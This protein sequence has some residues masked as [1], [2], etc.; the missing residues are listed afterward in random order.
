M[1]SFLWCCFLLL[2]GWSYGQKRPVIDSLLA[3]L[4]QQAD[5][6]K[7]LTY[8]QLCW[9][10][11]KEDVDSALA[12]GQKGLDLA[13]QLHFQR[14]VFE[15]YQQLG[16]CFGRQAN[17]PKALDYFLKALPIAETLTDQSRLARLLQNIGVIHITQQEYA[18]SLPFFNRALTVYKQRSDQAGQIEVLFLIAD[19]YVRLRQYDWGLALYKQCIAYYRANRLRFDLAIAL[20]DY[21]WALQRR[22]NFAESI[23]P[24][25]EAETLS[26]L[27]NYAQ[28]IASSQNG[29]AA[30]YLQTGN[31]Q[32]AEQ[33]GLRAL[34]T[35]RKIREWNDI[36]DIEWNL[37]RAYA[38]LGNKSEANTHFAAAEAA[39][40][41]VFGQQR[42]RAI[43]EVETRYQTKL[44][45]EQIAALNQKTRLQ[46]YLLGA[47]V[48]GGLLLLVV[49]VLLYNRYQL[50]DKEK[51]AIEQQRETE[52][53]LSQ[54]QQDKLQLEL[55]LKH[56]E[57]AS[58]A[59]FAYQKNEM[60]G[61]LK[62]QVDEL[63]TEPDKPQK[64][65]LKT[66]QK[67]IQS[68]LHFEDEWDAFKLHFEQVHPSFFEKLQHKFPDLT[69]NE[70]KLCAYTR[71][72]LSNKEIARLLNI[73]SSSV[74]MAR[75]RMK[76][77]VGLDG[78]TT[79][80]D[81]IQTV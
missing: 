77:K 52:R 75:Y 14:G 76:K 12:Y 6:A 57:L 34:A 40:D 60:L 13:R 44:K 72:N 63:L 61:Q 69:P 41:S 46:Q 39:Q 27:E 25:Q 26:G 54:A 80:T 8:A 56:R 11:G 78:Q 37:F 38:Y 50:R 35:A 47:G 5:T 51:R 31:Y 32:K 21:A 58:S 19:T 43:A 68:N 16:V 33:Y 1:R 59:L 81:F 15:G 9:H 28:G 3:V 71:I 65:K 10:Y 7:T 30:A 22:G 23:F 2:S 53:A 64:Q 48:L 42:S 45:D 70:L 29:L 17:Y 24:Y 67:F 20:R 62:E 66:I 4:P 74:E 55:D 73:N 18:K 49:L 36:K 79:I